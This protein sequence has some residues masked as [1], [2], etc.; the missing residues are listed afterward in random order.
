MKL[1]KEDKEIIR[2]YHESDPKGWNISALAR[3]WRVSRGT[4]QF[5][6]YPERLEKN[7]QHKKRREQ[8]NAKRKKK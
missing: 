7:Y 3:E 6:L 5:T 4:I 2:E 8:V 1:S